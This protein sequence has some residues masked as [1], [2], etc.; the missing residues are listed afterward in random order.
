MNGKISNLEAAALLMRSALAVGGACGRKSVRHFFTPMRSDK[1]DTFFI[2]T[3]EADLVRIAGLVLLSADGGVA[4]IWGDS[5]LF[6][7]GCTVN[8]DGLSLGEES[9]SRWLA[10][11][12]SIIA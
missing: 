7:K 5:S 10:M 2:R 6:R 9:P 3:W 8:W 1:D 11:A 12:L 4:I